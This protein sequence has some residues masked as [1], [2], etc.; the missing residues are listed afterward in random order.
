M[1][2]LLLLST[3][4]FMATT[5]YLLYRLNTTS[6]QPPCSTCFETN[7]DTP[8]QSMSLETA[9]QMIRNYKSQ[10]WSTIN[11]AHFSNQEKTDARSVWF[12][13]PVL[14]RFIYEMEH[15]TMTTCTDCAADLGIRFYYG[16]YPDQETMQS[17]PA[18]AEVPAEY[19]GMHT[20]LMV[21][22][23]RVDEKD[24]DFNP[25]DMEGCQPRGIQSGVNMI[26]SAPLSGDV[27][28]QNHGH[29]IPP[30]FNAN[31]CSG[32]RLLRLSDGITGDC[33]PE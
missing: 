5:T 29:L 18:Y 23:I 30:P 1:N 15:Q 25:H 3:L 19:A 28:L 2:R 26:L 24:I 32:A 33:S 14:K 6:N 9:L 11:E 4:V 16:S 12:S 17:N 20:L 10:Q 27:M 31:A 22:T 7:C 13:L 21:P 8:F